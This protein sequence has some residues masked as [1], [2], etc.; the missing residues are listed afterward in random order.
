MQAPVVLHIVGTSK[1]RHWRRGD[2]TTDLHRP[3]FDGVTWDPYIIYYTT[4]FTM[5]TSDF[6]TKISEK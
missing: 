5:I 4:R 6:M 1:L 3:P 2:L